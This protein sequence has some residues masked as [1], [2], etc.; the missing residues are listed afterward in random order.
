MRKSKESGAESR[1]R[2]ARL[3]RKRRTQ[4]VSLLG[5]GSVGWVSLTTNIRHTFWTAAVMCQQIF[6]LALPYVPFFWGK[7]LNIQLSNFYPVTLQY[8]ERTYRSVE[9]AYQ[10]LRLHVMGHDDRRAEVEGAPDGRKAKVKFN[11]IRKELKRQRRWP[12]SRVALW[13]TM[14]KGLMYSLVLEKFRAGS[15]QL[16]QFLM[17]TND[18]YLCETSLDREWGTGCFH[19]NPILKQGPSHISYG[20]NVMGEILMQV[21]AFLKNQVYE[22][23]T[24]SIPPPPPTTG[25]SGGSGTLKCPSLRSE[26]PTY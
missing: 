7:N 24:S 12:Q 23:V 20:K 1:R 14:Q 13:E 5:P 21:R 4:P 19:P 26:I 2:Q 15:Y 11:D 3:R 16:Y 18:L 22:S 17:Q 9:H 8:R 25:R 10:S 6:N